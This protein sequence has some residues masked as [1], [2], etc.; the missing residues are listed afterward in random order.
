M[1]I[2]LIALLF[3]LESIL[4]VHRTLSDYDP[5]LGWE[6]SYNFN[7]GLEWTMYNRVTLTVDNYNKLTKDLLFLMPVSNVTGF[8]Q[9]WNNIGELKNEGLEF[10]V[11]SRN[12]VSKDTK[13]CSQKMGKKFGLFFN[14]RFDFLR[15][16]VCLQKRDREN[17]NA[18][19]KK[20]FE[21][22]IHKKMQGSAEA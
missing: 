16:E 5:N 1:I 13:K 21:H 8:T 11:S 6:K 7:V 3:A 22:V 17:N 18:Q 20:N 9:Y 19:K 10:S 2:P 4:L 14:I 12:I 15:I